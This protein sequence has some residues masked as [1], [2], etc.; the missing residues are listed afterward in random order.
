MRQSTGGLPVTATAWLVIAICAIFG[1]QCIDAAYFH[2]EWTGR[3]ALFGPDIL[4][5]QVWELL[6]FQFLHGGILHLLCNAMALWW[7]G[8][9]AEN[10]MGRNRML[11]AY[12][13]SGLVGG[14]LEA[15]LAI[16]FPLQSAGVIMGASAGI[17]GLTAI[18]CLR[19]RD[20]TILIAGIV[21]VRSLHF[22]YGFA[23]ISL[24]FVLVPV[25][26]HWAHAAHLGGLLTGALW[27]WRGWFHEYQ[28]L[29]GQEL[30]QQ[31]VSGWKRRS[32][33]SSFRPRL[34][35]DSES[36][37]VMMPRIEARS[38]GREKTSS[39]LPRTEYISREVD[40]ILE[41]IA[42]HGMN[43]LSDD[44]HRILR[45]AKRRMTER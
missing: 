33:R 41:K 43:S 38:F 40:P 6:T 2:G 39:P 31:W 37:S 8:R 20:S 11:L 24:F 27:V 3:L 1:I 32:Q 14:M 28:P 16:L 7:V 9:Y 34:M 21:P 44:E 10:L 13:G 45:E 19:E 30:L 15:A 42:A 29:P 25:G 35:P 22:L 17:A 23:G 18:F 5:G 26:P 12:F 36:D 4:R